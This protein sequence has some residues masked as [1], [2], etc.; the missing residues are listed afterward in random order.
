MNL[1]E[2]AKNYIKPFKHQIHLG[3]QQNCIDDFK[4]GYKEC[5][6]DISEFIRVNPKRTNQ[7][8]TDYLNSL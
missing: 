4:N 5:I 6:S 1:E 8:I 7:Q 3:E 2:K